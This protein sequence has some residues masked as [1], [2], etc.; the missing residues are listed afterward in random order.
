[1]LQVEG[2]K[3]KKRARGANINNE[4]NAKKLK[5]VTVFQRPFVGVPAD[6]FG[7]D[8]NLHPC[9]EP[10]FNPVPILSQ[11]SR[12]DNHPNVMNF[13]KRCA[14]NLLIFTKKIAEA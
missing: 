1:M 7:W 5:F 12:V 9:I 10:S 13:E 2:D 4:K 6:R 14:K 3:Y 11:D 8:L